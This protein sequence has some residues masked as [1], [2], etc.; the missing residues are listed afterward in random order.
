MSALSPQDRE[1]LLES[2][3]QIRNGEVKNII[4]PEYAIRSLVEV[5]ERTGLNWKDRQVYLIERGGKWRPELSIDAFRLIANQDENYN[6][7]TE[8]LWTLSPDGPW[9]DIPPDKIP[10][11]AKVGV[12]RKGQTNPTWGQVKF[13]DYNPGT[14]MWKKMG[15]TMIAKCAEMLALRKALPGKLSGLYGREEMEQVD[16]PSKTAQKAKSEPTFDPKTGMGIEAGF[17]QAIETAKD[18]V[19][20]KVIGTEIQATNLDQEVKMRLS[21]AYKARK[22]AG[23]K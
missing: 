23:W 1:L 20:L 10:Y 5:C 2:L 13:S 21:I 8:A 6:G 4:P 18:E 19:T 16:R 3:K 7:Q 9:T 11:A 14:P 15:T 17:L 22:E 12:Y